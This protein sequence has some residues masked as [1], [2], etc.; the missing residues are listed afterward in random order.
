M[1]KLIF[2]LTT[3]TVVLLS[4]CG[5]KVS[6]PLIGKWKLADISLPKV[7]LTSEVNTQVDTMGVT[8]VDTAVKAMAKGMEEMT[9]AMTGMGDALANAFL[10]GSTYNFKDDG[11]VE[12]SILFGSQK[13]TYTVTPDNKEVTTKIDG[14]E[15]KY[16]ITSVNE[17]TLVLT[18]ATGET[19]TFEAK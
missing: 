12:V 8:G 18:S 16:T 4:S 2:A 19:W 6:N 11:N 1:K 3:V 14:K 13:G 15:E 17:T 10:K 9:N 7:D 5:E